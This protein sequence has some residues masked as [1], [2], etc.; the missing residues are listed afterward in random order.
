MS[1]ARI[2]ELLSEL[3]DEIVDTALNNN[4]PTHPKPSPKPSP[5][6]T[7]KPS[8]PV[9]VT[10]DNFREVLAGTVYGNFVFRGGSYVLNEPIRIGGGS[11]I[12][13]NGENVEIIR[14]SPSPSAK[15]LV[16]YLGKKRGDLLIEGLSFDANYFGRAIRA[17]DCAGLT[18]RDCSIT[19]TDNHAIDTT[20]A[21]YLRVLKS[22]VRFA[23]Y[24]RPDG[25]R[26]DAHCITSTNTPETTIRQ[27]SCNYCSGDSFQLERAI[28]ADTVL[29][30]DCDFRNDPLPSDVATMDGRKLYYKGE[31]PGENAIDTKQGEDGS[32]TLVT[33]KDC[34][35]DG[36]RSVRS[37]SSPPDKLGDK[38][39]FIESASAVNMKEN[40]RLICN[41]VTITNSEIGW[42]LRGVSKGVK[43]KGIVVNGGSTSACDIMVNLEDSIG[44]RL[45]DGSDLVEFHNHKFQWTANTEQFIRVWGGGLPV[46]AL[47][48]GCSYVGFPKPPQKL[49]EGLKL[50]WDFSKTPAERLPQ[51]ITIK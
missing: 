37:N 16:Y 25:R 13:A 6:P 44:N 48:E 15:T 4:P 14:T 32:V 3:V 47:F 17:K 42:R 22:D 30:E 9:E 50:G 35:F 2:K 43:T 24:R 46:R 36:W 38:P 39:A 45:A 12:A 11:L 49:V 21:A 26:G 27:T 33:L 19:H 29:I 8:G 7:P 23:L 10:P 41:N 18:I 20:R 1:V 51:A 40:V 34:R 28:G 5:K 31:R